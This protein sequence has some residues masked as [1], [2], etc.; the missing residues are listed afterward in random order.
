VKKY[1]T[2][3]QLF[4]MMFLQYAVIT[5]NIRAVAVSSYWALALTDLVISIL[6]FTILKKVEQANGVIDMAGYALGG[7]LG[8]QVAMFIGNLYIH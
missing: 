5:F 8:A 7:T 2:S 4:V 1:K 3:A 6:G